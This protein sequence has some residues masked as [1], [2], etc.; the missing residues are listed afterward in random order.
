MK[1]IS[2]IG[3]PGT[4]VQDLRDYRE[5]AKDLGR[6]GG[7]ATSK[8]YGKEHYR[9]IQALGVVTKNKRKLESKIGS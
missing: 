4:T 8:K 5:L 3:T 2:E 7:S 9:R 6:R 1:K